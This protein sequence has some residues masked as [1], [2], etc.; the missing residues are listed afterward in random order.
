MTDMVERDDAWRPIDSA[1]KD[2]TPILVC[3]QYPGSD[4]IGIDRYRND[5]WWRSTPYNQPQYWMPLPVPPDS[6]AEPQP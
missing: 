3:R 4:Q 6:T 5:V 2:G 1:P